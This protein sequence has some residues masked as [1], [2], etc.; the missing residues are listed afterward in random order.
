MP[1]PR[2]VFRIGAGVRCADGAC[3]ELRCLVIDPATDSVTDLVVEEPH[4]QGLGQM[5]PL[6]QVTAATDE[7]VKLRC[8]LAEFWQLKPADETQFLPG[9]R[10]DEDYGDEQVIS[11]PSYPDRG[12]MPGSS[13]DNVPWVSETVTFDLVAEGKTEVPR[14]EHVHAT[15]GDIGRV[16]GVIVDP[17]DRRVTH[18]LLR[19]G[20][21]WGRRELAIPRDAVA[22]V[23]ADGFHLN[24]TRQ[25]VQDLPG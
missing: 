24:L 17:R 4:R 14:G 7:A 22:S 15:D 10:G 3:G 5:V 8:S 19:E 1:E 11:W 16:Q 23:D 2:L 25:D 9:T 12:G 13:A 6:D 21:L 18:V 20:R